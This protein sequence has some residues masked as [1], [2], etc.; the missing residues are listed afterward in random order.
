M[1]SFFEWIWQRIKPT[2]F[3]SEGYMS[4]LQ[5][6]MKIKVKAE[7]WTPAGR[8]KAITL[9]LSRLAA[10]QLIPKHDDAKKHVEI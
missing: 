7:T 10:R 5:R 9:F 8:K 1:A 4:S 2:A 6:I 3:S